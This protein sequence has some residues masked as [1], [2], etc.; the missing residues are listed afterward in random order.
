MDELTPELTPSTSTPATEEST[1]GPPPVNGLNI[2]LRALSGLGGGIIGTGLILIISLLASGILQS[3]LQT[4]NGD[5]TVHPLFVFVFLAMIFLGSTTTNLLGPLFMGLSDREKYKRLS[6]SLTQIFIANIVIFILVV[7]IY[8]IVAGM[9]IK[10]IA[11]VAALQVIVS[12]FSSALI[13]EIIAN[14]RYALLGVYSTAFA[15]V[16]SSGLNFIFYSIGPDNPTFLLFVA[17]P[18]IWL[19]IGLFNGLLGWVYGGVYKLYGTDFLS[20]TIKYGADQSWLSEAEEQQQQ[21]DAEQHI[22]AK[23]EDEGATFLNKVDQ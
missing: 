12:S 16:I 8:V 9:N 21:L 11:S 5:G 13:L 19:C 23:K 2:L 6:T 4:E 7:P 1:F 10:M 20:S 22:Q 17:L 18:L 14:Y 3:A 15:V